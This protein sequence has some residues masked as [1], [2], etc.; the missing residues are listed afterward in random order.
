MLIHV[1]R[2]SLACA[3]R[4]PSVVHH[5][6][7]PSRGTPDATSAGEAKAPFAD[8][9][10]SCSAMDLPLHPSKGCHSL[11]R[12]RFCRK[13]PRLAVRTTCAWIT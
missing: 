1:K 9:D 12:R 5:L 8:A 13:Q 2:C 7:A 4:T 6:R 10:S 3:G 11:R